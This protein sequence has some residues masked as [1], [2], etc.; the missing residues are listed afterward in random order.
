MALMM[1]FSK[2]NEKQYVKMATKS[3]HD[4]YQ[5]DNIYQ[6]LRIAKEAKPDMVVMRF[7]KR[8]NMN[9]E[10]MD[11]IRQSLC[12]ENVCPPIYLNVPDDFDGEVFFKNMD[13][14]KEDVQKY[15][16]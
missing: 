4:C 3:G 13:F 11:E 16:N 14:A 6:F 7:S 1:I 15:L 2:R 8:F 5:T 10:L 9:R 12:D